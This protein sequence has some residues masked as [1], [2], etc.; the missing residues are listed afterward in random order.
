METVVKAI[1]PFSW[2]ERG[3]NGRGIGEREGMIYLLGVLGEQAQIFS[4]T[5]HHIPHGGG[6]HHDR[7]AGGFLFVPRDQQLRLAPGQG[8]AESSEG[9]T[10]HLS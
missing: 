4:I 2:C 3:Q 7:A 5:L 6:R 9:R 8:P 1:K 10:S